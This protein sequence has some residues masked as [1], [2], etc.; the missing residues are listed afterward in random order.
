MNKQKN[1][2]EWLVVLGVSLLSVLA[3]L[4]LTNTT[5]FR[6]LELKSLDMRFG[7]R[8]PLEIED[9][10]VVIIK[11]DDQSDESTPHR[12]PW[13]RSYF[14]HVLRNLNE[15]GVKAIGVDVI[16]DQP[17]KFGEKEDDQLREVLTTYDNIVLAGKISRTF[18]QGYSKSTVIPPYEKFITPQSHW[19]LVSLE[20]D[21]DGFYRRYIVSDVHKDSLY[22]SFA[23]ML[24]KIYTDQESAKLSSDEESFHIGSLTIPKYDPSSM[25]V[26]FIGPAY[27][28]PNYSFDNILDTEDFDL[29]EDYDLDSFDDPGDPE[30]GISP[31][32]KYSGILKDK[33][34]LIGSTMQELHDNF[35]TPFL[36][37]GGN[38]SIMAK[39]EM[40]GVEIH[41]NALLTM[42]Q[43]RFLQRVPLALTIGNILLALLLTF[44]ATRFLPTLWSAAAVFAG[45]IGFVFGAIYLF[46]SYNMIIEMV[47]PT[48]VVGFA[49]MGH[50]LY[51]YLQ[52]QREKR[53]LRGAFAQYV[54]EK[55]VEDIVA[56]PE[57]LQLGGEERVV[58]V[59]FSDVAGFTS[60]SEKLSPAELVILLNEYLTAMT[61]IVMEHNGI[62]DKYEGDAIMAEFGVPVPF[63]DH[64]QV[65][66]R[67]ALR[68]Q[69]KL[70][71]M[72]AKW[73]EEGR[74]ELEAR[75][76]INTGEM[77]VGNMGS[78]TVFDYTVM[79]DHVNL[80]S[81][82]EGANKQ[83]GT[84]IM[85]SEFT[86]AYV[87]NDFYTRPLD[88]IRVKGKEQ[89]IEV[90]ELIA[91][92]KQT[93]DST[94]LEMLSVYQR[95]VE[96]YRKRAWNEAIEFFEYALSLREND[97]P[98]KLYR[99]RCLEFKLN[100]PGPDWD[101]VF[102]MTTK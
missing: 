40:P 16:F 98:S 57:K 15:A 17:D 19:G 59:M 68:M 28:F 8:G 97:M 5:T 76:G 27:S 71:E 70:V 33:I 50:I 49:Y 88:L 31:G 96:A 20:S 61:N 82:L 100:N 53:M 52:T 74:P 54:P 72:R 9:N 75:I 45:F 73:K 10:P 81:R 83:Y 99:K 69:E 78:Q 32:L 63:D 30:F 86:H 95:G 85:I 37:A 42:L 7:L 66:C 55:V 92:R 102:T 62:I 14:A 34:V 56:N 39:V 13:P 26:N 58:S 51:H 94:Y 24:Y 22:S 2:P 91:E 44:L 64:P 11:I 41:A 89:P 29:L 3:A 18:E 25:L 87:K 65:A 23:A 12:W 90:F 36:D 48:L 6:T 80:A 35:P 60:I 84:F 47:L 43:N 79:G 93:L 1:I 67:V 4:F 46:S 101:G 21:L 77:I 38:D